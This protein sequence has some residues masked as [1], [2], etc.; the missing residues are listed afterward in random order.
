VTK[1]H[2]DASPSSSE[3]WLQ[4]PASVTKARGRQRL[5]TIYTREGSAAHGVAEGLLRGGKRQDV[6][7]QIEIDGEMIQV[8][9][10]MLNAAETY[11]AYVR[12]LVAMGCELHIETKVR[13]D[14][15]GEILFGT[16][17]AFVID[18]MEK[19]V[20]NVDFK[21]GQGV[22]VPPDAPQF[23]IY[24]LGV[25]DRL[26]PFADIETVIL[27]VVQPRINPLPQSVVLPVAE[28]AR[29]ERDVLKPALERIAADDPTETP[30]E[31]CRW[32][33]RAGECAALA[34]RAQAIAKTSFGVAPPS[35]AALSDDELGAVLDQAELIASWVAHV[36]AEASMRLDQ[37]STVPGW[38]LVAK[39]A[40]RKWTDGQAVIMEL[41]KRGVDVLDIVRVETITHVEAVMKR[42]KI[43]KSVIDPYTVKE[44]SG[45]TLVSDKDPR[46]SV[47]TTAKGVFSEANA[48][49]YIE[50]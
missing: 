50:G 17:D 33:V 4:C 25:L 42:R 15:A 12:S 27:T 23:R 2:A 16:S 28:L 30:G 44:S 10:E 31:H 38:K 5:P 21:Y 49:D 7:A 47:D 18:M 14:I 1:K 9:E 29:W 6:Q 45:T 11:V 13:I 48:L 40:A 35:P 22:A 8:S 41:A 32:C 20:E 39:R 24:G 43:P 37:G 3:I 26:G 19:T 34:T 36:R 46:N